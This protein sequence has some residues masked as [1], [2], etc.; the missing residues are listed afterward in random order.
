MM[1]IWGSAAVDPVVQV[2]DMINT[3]K[4]AAV[5]SERITAELGPNAD[6]DAISATATLVCHLWGSVI[7]LCIQSDPQQADEI[8]R[9]DAKMIAQHT[10][11]L[12]G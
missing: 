12:I 11:S 5:L 3:R 4:N 8:I 2:A 7:R 9:Q 6:L 10:Q 1:V